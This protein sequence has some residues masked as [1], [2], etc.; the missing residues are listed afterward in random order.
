MRLN[1][2]DDFVERVYSLPE[3]IV[4]LT[5]TRIVLDNQVVH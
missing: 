4:I 1:S 3:C 5:T 2:I